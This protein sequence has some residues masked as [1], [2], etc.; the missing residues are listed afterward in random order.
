MSYDIAIAVKVA[1]AEDIYATVGEPEWRSPTY[2]LGKLFRACME[3]NY[4]QSEIGEDGEYHT[5]YYKC[6]F[7]L[8]RIEQG[9]REI[10][11]NRSA[12]VHLLPENGWGTFS[13]AI[14]ALESTRE[15]I[16]ELAEDIPLDCLY[17]KW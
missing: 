1:G 9:I 11:T 8:E 4:S 3:W 10:R 5:C 6:D 14:E 7:A 15:C 12:Y 2:N 16:F 13:S 17:M